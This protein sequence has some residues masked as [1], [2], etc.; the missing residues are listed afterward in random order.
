[1]VLSHTGNDNNPIKRERAFFS[2]EWLWS[3]V[4]SD[5]QGIQAISL[6]I[7]GLVME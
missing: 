1:M 3:V 6:Q 2:Y 5:K 7:E 4:V